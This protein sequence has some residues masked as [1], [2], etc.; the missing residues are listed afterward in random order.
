M[1]VRL[2]RLL[3]EATRLLQGEWSDETASGKPAIAC[4]TCGDISELPETHKVTA[5]GVVTPIWSCPAAAC[6]C[7]DFLIFEAYSEEVV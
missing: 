1:A 2:R 6:P 7:S 3:A 4:P 5:D